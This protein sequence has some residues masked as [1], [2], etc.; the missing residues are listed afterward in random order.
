M[1]DLDK[2]TPRIGLLQFD[3]ASATL[4]PFDSDEGREAQLS[5]YALLELTRSI[6]GMDWTASVGVRQIS[7]GGLD[8]ASDPEHPNRFSL[9]MRG[10]SG[11]VQWSV[12]DPALS[13]YFRADFVDDAAAARRKA[14][15]VAEELPG[16]LE[17]PR[18]VFK[19]QLSGDLNFDGL[20][21]WNAGRLTLE[22]PFS[23]D[24]E[25]PPRYRRID[26]DLPS[27]ALALLSTAD[28]EM[29]A[30]AGDAPAGAMFFV[31]AVA[32]PSKASGELR[33]QPV[34]FSDA[35]EGAVTGQSSQKQLQNAQ[36]LW[37]GC[38]I[39]IVERG[40]AQ[41]LDVTLIAN[42]ESASAIAQVWSPPETHIVTV[43]YVDAPLAGC[44]GAETLNANSN[45]AKIVITD[46]DPGDPVNN[47]N[48]LAHELGHVFKAIH[49]VG[50]SISG[51]WRPD[52]GTVMAATNDARIAND[53]VNTPRNRQLAMGPS[54]W[55]TPGAAGCTPE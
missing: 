45:I 53:P 47:L 2:S 13:L 43:F 10:R 42:E 55:P 25:D 20:L 30:H 40:A 24:P 23:E 5:G 46:L 3:S 37:A 36:K 29:A 14:L 27:T 26:I 8:P 48:L 19:G 18:D 32:R 34:F 22:E 11:P 16:V 7:I 49:P 21:Y 39:D 52:A 1:I 4:Y 33:L 9:V 28:D 31:A 38:C 44:G 41:Q 6:D 15:P 35:A 50:A 17:T 12:G 51:W 54:V